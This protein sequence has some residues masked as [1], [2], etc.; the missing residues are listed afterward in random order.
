MF[1]AYAGFVQWRGGL[2]LVA[3]RL[4]PFHSLS[5]VTIG[6]DQALQP[7]ARSRPTAATDPLSVAKYSL[8]LGFA[9]EGQRKFA[10]AED[11]FRRASN[12]FEAALGA[13][14]LN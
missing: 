9:N 12:D 1:T 11:A 4:R 6:V 8:L 10:E 3:K 5:S 13:D 7:P 2:Y 14:D